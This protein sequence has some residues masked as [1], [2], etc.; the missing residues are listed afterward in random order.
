[1]AWGR[2]CGRLAL[3]VCVPLC[4]LGLL[5][6]GLRRGNAGYPTAFL[7]PV[8]IDGAPH[9]VNNP[10]Y[11]YRFFDPRLARNP[12]PISVAHPAPAGVIRVAV[13]GESAA[14]G[15]PLL[16]YG[17]PRTLEK[18]LNARPDGPR[19]EVINAAMTAINSHVIVDIAR[20][21]AVAR[22]DIVVLYIG[23]NEV[24]GPYGPGTVFT[25]WPG[26]TALTPLRVRLTRLRTASWLRGI[27]AHWPGEGTPPAQWAGL[28][29]F[30]NAAFAPDDPRL[31]RMY[32]RFGANLARIIDLCQAYG[33]R[34]I[35]STVAVNLSDCPPFDPNAEAAHAAY[36]EG[37]FAE[38]RDLD[39]L[40]FRADSR[41]N[42]IIRDV[43]GAAG[44]ELVDAEVLFAEPGARHFLDHVHFTME[45]NWILARAIAARIAHVS[46]DR[47]PDIAETK[48]LL[49][50]TPWA[51]RAQAALMLERR[52]R[53]P[54][55]GQQDNTAW[56]Q[57]LADHIHAA[58][59][60]IANTDLATVE[61]V[62]QALAASDPGDV[63]LPLHWG[64]ILCD[65]GRW[66]EAVPVL[67]GALHRLPLHNEARRLP[68]FALA[69]SG[70]SA[71]AARLLRGQPP[72]GFYL[73]EQS[74]D[75]IR[76]LR[77]QGYPEEARSVLRTL[78]DETPHFPNRAAVVELLEE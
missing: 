14:Q 54:F 20:E 63:F 45:G 74:I 66:A 37:R 31:E 64:G 2:R 11:G 60:E 70:R 55:V 15:D 51:E 5:E 23:N 17:L 30:A 40:R 35:V 58:N 78:L 49:F 52:G 75:M 13:L 67:T 36:R 7:V 43:A 8:E 9:L 28:A 47:L 32:R 44:T 57:R 38:A 77:R 50:F 46:P 24:I 59:A 73:A 71:E 53:P 29:M 6:W 1:M 18:L 76:T 12:A 56:M 42:R 22:P 27:R 16:E 68:A 3:A 26:A 10:F 69:R 19:H 48:R 39:P 62:F 4:V 34:V 61:T 41:I 72:Y 25:A 65:A 33:A 21:L